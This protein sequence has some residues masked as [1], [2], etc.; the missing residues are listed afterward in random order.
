MQVRGRNSRTHAYRRVC[1]KLTCKLIS[2][3]PTTCI[4]PWRQTNQ[5]LIQGLGFLGLLGTIGVPSAISQVSRRVLSAVARN[6]MM[7]ST[8][9]LKI[10]ETINK[11]RRPHRVGKAAEKVDGPVYFSNSLIDAIN[12]FLKQTITVHR[13]G[14]GRGSQ[15]SKQI[16]PIFHGAVKQSHFC[17]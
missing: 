3:T 11:G 7:W 16:V 17:Q 6:G 5:K 8:Q 13:Q 15:R 1:T 4:I 12:S 9:Q 14:E 10:D 2:P